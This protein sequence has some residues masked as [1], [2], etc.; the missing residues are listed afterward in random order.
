MSVE[1]PTILEELGSLADS[2]AVHATYYENA[3][4]GTVNLSGG[5]LAFVHRAIARLCELLAEHE[6]RLAAAA[7]ANRV[8]DVTAALAPPAPPPATVPQQ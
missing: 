4:L 1:Q 7:D 6:S 2:A 8:A 5:E 3:A